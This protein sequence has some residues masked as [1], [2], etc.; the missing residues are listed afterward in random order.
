MLNIVI[1]PISSHACWFP[2]SGYFPWSPWKIGVFTRCVES[3]VGQKSPRHVM[4]ISNK[5]VLNVSLTHLQDL[6]PGSWKGVP[7]K[8]CE[9]WFTIPWQLVRYIYHKSKREIRVMFTNLAILEAPPCT[10]PTNETRGITYLGV[11]LHHQVASLLINCIHQ[12]LPN[13][14]FG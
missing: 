7:P 1:L 2:K 6:V 5:N 8:L 13:D 11:A 4:N 9:R 12:Y 10:Y 14:L 3:I